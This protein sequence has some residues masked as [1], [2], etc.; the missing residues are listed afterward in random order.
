MAVMRIDTDQLQ[1]IELCQGTLVLHKD[2]MPPVVVLV[3]ESPVGDLFAGVSLDDGVQLDT[4]AVEDFTIFRGS[5]SLS[6]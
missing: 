5:L 6:Q 1:Q 2:A 4:W 3:T